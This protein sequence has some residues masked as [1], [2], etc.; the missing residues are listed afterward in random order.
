M[1]SESPDY[2][3]IKRAFFDSELVLVGENRFPKTKEKSY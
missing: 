3:I 1:K 2:L